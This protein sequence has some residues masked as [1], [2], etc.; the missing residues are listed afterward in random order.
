MRCVYHGWKFG[1]SGK[2]IDLPNNPAALNIKEKVANTAYPA[3]ELL[4]IV[5]VY[6]GPASHLP[7]LPKFEVAELENA[8]L[9][10][11]FFQRE[12][13]YLQALEGDIDTSHLGFLHVGNIEEDQLGEDDLMRHVVSNRAPELE[14]SDA[15]W[16]TTY[17][18]SKSVDGGGRYLRYANFLF[19]FWTQVP[20]GEFETNIIARAW[21]PMDDFHTMALAIGWRR[22]PP[23]FKPM[24]NGEPLPGVKTTE[25]LPNS[26]DWYGRFRTAQ[27]SSNDYLIDREAQSTNRIFTG[28]ESINVQDQ[29]VTESMGAIT[30]RARE[31]LTPSDLMIARTRRRLLRAARALAVEGAEPPGAADP[32]VYRD[33]RSGEMFVANDLPSQDVYQEKLERAVRASQM[34]GAE[35]VGDGD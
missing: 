18:A 1:P 14:V 20:Q 35:G 28:I 31:H 16:G 27:N 34:V 5:W 15:P 12:C 21:V 13:N 23:P 3:K 32:L 9:N 2:C 33:A 29:A 11:E 22:R 6:M 24:K 7:E 8:E 19:P 30:D 26:T 10:I 4:G 17:C 25:M